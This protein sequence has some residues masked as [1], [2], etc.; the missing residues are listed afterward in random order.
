MKR[1]GKISKKKM[2]FKMSHYLVFIFV[3][4][5]NHLAYSAPSKNLSR[6]SLAS[7]SVMPVFGD[8]GTE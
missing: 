6:S 1:Q 7:V 3:D 2:N 5:G 8:T 4:S